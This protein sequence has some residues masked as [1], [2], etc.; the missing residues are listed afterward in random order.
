MLWNIQLQ[1]LLVIKG[2][3]STKL[4]MYAEMRDLWF[5]PFTFVYLLANLQ[6]VLQ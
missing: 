4:S 2:E 6:L 5:C 3:F 1:V